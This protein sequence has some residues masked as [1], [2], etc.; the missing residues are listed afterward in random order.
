MIAT[1][2][3]TCETVGDMPLNAADQGVNPE[4]Q[5]PM[6]SWDGQAMENWDAWGNMHEGADGYGA[7]EEQQYS[8]QTARR[9]SERRSAKEA[10]R[11]AAAACSEQPGNGA[12]HEEG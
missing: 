8:S 7:G 9:R 1:H 11:R 10:A 5:M 12:Y 2:E 6:E 4:E 3:G